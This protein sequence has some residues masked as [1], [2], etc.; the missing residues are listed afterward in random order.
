MA[1]AVW[2]LNPRFAEVGMGGDR[3]RFIQH[4]DKRILLVDVSHC[5][6]AEVEKISRLVP[7]FLS[8]EPKGSVL[9][10]GDFTGAEVTKQAA[11][12]LKQDTVFDR[13][14]LKRSAW[15]GTDAI[16][17]ALFEN[18]KTFSRRDLP[19]FKTREEALEW[20]VQD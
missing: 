17:H 1:P 18:I 4:K 13:P 6:A 19:N 16:P 12:R 3:V 7:S 9:V 15:V 2:N 20:L 8:S 14:Y 5:N 10:L 11:E